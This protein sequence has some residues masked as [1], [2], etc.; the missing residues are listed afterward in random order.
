MDKEQFGLFIAEE[1]KKHNMTQ[2]QLAEKVHVS[3]AAVSKWERC[4]CLPDLTKLEDI[5]EVLD[6]SLMELIQCKRNAVDDSTYRADDVQDVLHSTVQMSGN[7]LKRNKKKIVLLKAGLGIAVVIA[8]LLGYSLFS[9]P[10]TLSQLYP[11]IKIDQCAEIKGYYGIGTQVNDTEFGFDRSDED[12]WKLLMLFNEQEYRRSLKDL[13]PR[14]TK[15]H[16]AEGNNDFWWDVSLRFDEF[17][18]PDGS[19]SSGFLRFHNWY[20]DL[21]IYFDG[22][23]YACFTRESK[24]YDSVFELLSGND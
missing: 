19:I 24:L 5:A 11:M 2:G 10:M 13:L 7:E 3:T 16:R 9:R 14:T 21:E 20:G 17:T 12:F 4:L 15:T 8:L 18:M 22:E 23:A 1:R 6:L